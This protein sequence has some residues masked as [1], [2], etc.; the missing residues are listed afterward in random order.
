[1]LARKLNP[2]MNVPGPDQSL[3]PSSS[4]SHG[5]EAPSSLHGSVV[6][7]RDFNALDSWLATAPQAGGFAVIACEDELARC[8]SI[9][10]H[11]SRR[12]EAAAGRV[13][14]ISGLEGS[15]GF[16]ELVRALTPDSTSLAVQTSRDTAACIIEQLA[17]RA[18]AQTAIVVTDRE[19]SRFA[20]AVA[21]DLDAAWNARSAEGAPRALPPVVWVVGSSGVDRL[22][23]ALPAAHT[24][25]QLFIVDREL[26]VGAARSWWEAARNQLTINEPARVELLEQWWRGASA[27]LAA[28]LS[29]SDVSSEQVEQTLITDHAARMLALV[30]RAWPV[31]ALERLGLTDADVTRLVSAGLADVRTHL[32]PVAG[33]PSSGRPSSRARMSVVLRAHVTLDQL[34]DLGALTIE[35]VRRAASALESRFDGDAWAMLRAA[36]VLLRGSASA[37]SHGED[38]SAL[39]KDGDRLALAVLANTTDAEARVDFWSKLEA[40]SPK[41]S[42]T[43]ER[44]LPYVDLALRKGDGDWAL[45]IARAAISVTTQQIG[46]AHV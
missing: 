46:R 39:L 28:H 17:S 41:P 38:A 15:E 7:A 19:P 40:A 29:Q 5:Q 26:E 23:A 4:G 36:E 3:A 8:E 1:M 6:D 21:A 27:D 42:P 9:A 20:L 35:G 37:V 16:R 33:P 11:A 13:L 32:A 18:D 12:F 2:Q 43:A 24:S 30:G 10:D 14:R 45:K 34:E 22:A 44:L 25:G 31:D